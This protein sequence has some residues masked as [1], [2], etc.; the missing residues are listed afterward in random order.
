MD[1]IKEVLEQRTKPKSFGMPVLSPSYCRTKEHNNKNE[2]L[3]NPEKKEGF[4]M[5][6]FKQGAMQIKDGNIIMVDKQGDLLSIDVEYIRKEMGKHESGTVM[7]RK[8]RTWIYMLK[9][10]EMVQEV[11]SEMLAEVSAQKKLN[12]IRKTLNFKNR[13]FRDHSI[14]QD[15]ISRIYKLM[16]QWAQWLMFLNMNKK[17]EK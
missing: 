8:I 5:R 13:K 16:G 2:K 14:K 12:P 1:I 9:F 10:P 11:R 3:F 7:G 17:K 4:S 15:G 6:P